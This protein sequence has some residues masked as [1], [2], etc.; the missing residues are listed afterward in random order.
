LDKLKTGDEIIIERGDGKTINYNV[1]ED[2][3][4]SLHDANTTGMKRLMTPYDPNKEG[5]GLITCAGNYV[6]SDRLFNERILVRAV[7]E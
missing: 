1:V 7:A 2:I 5:L 4:E 6:P 3:T